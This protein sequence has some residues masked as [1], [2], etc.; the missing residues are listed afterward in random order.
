[1][2][3]LVVAD[4]LTGATDTALQF[5]KMNREVVIIT[6]GENSVNFGPEASLLVLNTETRGLTPS[7]AHK[8]VR[9]QL[10]VLGDWE[11]QLVFKKID[12]TLR[13]NIGSEID[14][15]MTAY[16]LD[17][18]AIAPA[19]PENGRYTIGGYQL[20]HGSLL[21]DL[22]LASSGE[23]Q[24]MGSFVP[25]VLAAQTRRRIGHVGVETIRHSDVMGNTQ[26]FLHLGGGLLVFDSATPRDMDKVVAGLAALNGRVLWVGSAGLAA[27]L[28]R[29]LQ[30][31]QPTK[32]G[33]GANQPLKPQGQVLLVAGSQNPVTSGQVGKLIQSG[34]A[35]L[36]AVPV[37]H[38]I[39]ETSLQDYIN[40][41]LQLLKGGRNLAL[42]IDQTEEKNPPKRD[43][44]DRIAQ[45]LTA[46]AAAI[47]QAW[48]LAGVVATGGDI[49]LHTWRQLNLG[50]LSVTGEIEEGIPVCVGRHGKEELLFVTKAGGFGGESALLKA[51][52]ML[53]GEGV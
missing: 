24:E 30:L 45:R 11:P 12:S 39:D 50:N 10:A 48:P 35:S 1:M 31:D 43:V 37:R 51:V 52:T 41:G 47:A 44:S 2:N 17:L 28:A 33:F 3:I 29:S 38:L 53:K 27:A 7:E 8:K 9:A 25:S 36:L 16:N 14:G 34:K 19:Y 5:A 18:A 40:R 46:I 21:E 26:A 15:L 20:V 49:A 42:T 13:G 4:D 6:P 23:T 22:E 32:N